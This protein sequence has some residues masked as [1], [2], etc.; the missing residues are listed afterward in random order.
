MRKRM[1]LVLVLVFVLVLSLVMVVED[2]HVDVFLGMILVLPHVA[3]TGRVCHLA[4]RAKCE[5]ISESG[6]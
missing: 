3:G 2:V 6:G 4:S 1:A 5:W